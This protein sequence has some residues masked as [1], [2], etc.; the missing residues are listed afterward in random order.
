MKDLI[1]I[2][3]LANRAGVTTSSLRFYDAEGLI[4]SV[5]TSG[6]QRRYHR[7]VIRRVSFIKIAQGIG[8]ELDAIRAALSSLPNARTP[9]KADW[10][11]LSRSWRPM[12]DARIAV[13]ERTRDQ[14][15]ECIGCGCL[16]LRSC[17]LYNPSDGAASF[18]AGARYLLG[19]DPSAVIGS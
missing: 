3:E 18:G 19:D 9:T 10:E 4:H 15:T 12:L 17:A 2:G 6:G 11:K 8:L 7:E 1:S 13:L 16:S 5:R 14:L